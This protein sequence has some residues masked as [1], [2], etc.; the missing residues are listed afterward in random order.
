MFSVICV[1][2]FILSYFFCVCSMFCF[3][4]RFI[5]LLSVYLLCTWC[6]RST[7]LL[8]LL[9]HLATIM[10][11]WTS[12]TKA[13]TRLFTFLL[14]PRPIISRSSLFLLIVLRSFLLLLA[15]NKPC[16]ILLPKLFPLILYLSL[17]LLRAVRYHNVV[18]VVS[19]V[20]FSFFRD[21]SLYQYKHFLPGGNVHLAAIINLNWQPWCLL[22]FSRSLKEGNSS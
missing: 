12:I 7:R 10:T 6:D 5:C 1:F 4:R 11:F 9:C 19:N 15:K 20:F 18:V 3:T 2:P 21:A 17:L 8:F 16:A 14:L 22:V 13:H